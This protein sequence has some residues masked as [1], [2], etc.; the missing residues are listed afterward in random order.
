MSSQLTPVGKHPQVGKPPTLLNLTKTNHHV[1]NIIQTTT[2][3]HGTNNILQN[4]F[5]IHTECEEYLICI[6]LSVP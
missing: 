6:I 5:P 4:I 3:L 2:M 1:Y